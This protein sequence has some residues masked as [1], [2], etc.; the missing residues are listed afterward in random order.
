MQAVRQ[1]PAHRQPPARC[2]SQDRWH[3]AVAL[4]CGAPSRRMVTAMVLTRHIITT[5][6]GIRS[7]GGTAMIA[8]RRTSSGPRAVLLNCCPFPPLVVVH[9]P[10]AALLCAHLSR[11]SADGL[12]MR[13]RAETLCGAAGLS[14]PGTRR[15]GNGGGRRWR[16]AWAEGARW[17][18]VRRDPGLLRGVSG[19]DPP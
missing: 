8:T 4:P 18:P 6:S 5:I 1:L 17:D 12:V 14:A 3:S 11:M 2:C 13:H 7:R 15:R 19:T 9:I 16:V 10:G